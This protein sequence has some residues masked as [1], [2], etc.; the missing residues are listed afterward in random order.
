VAGI[1]FHA[2]L[3][4]AAT[5]TAF[6]LVH[7]G[8]PSRAPTAAFMTLALSQSL[9]LVNARNDRRISGR[10]HVSNPYA[11]AGVGLAVLL[12]LATAVIHPLAAILRVAPL[13]GGEWL[14]VAAASVSPALIGQI[15]KSP[16]APQRA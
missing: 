16:R 7:L 5:L 1:A 10:A 15:A 8:D 2:V 6:F 12:Q 3:I 9:H 11:I 4:T 13:S 14:I